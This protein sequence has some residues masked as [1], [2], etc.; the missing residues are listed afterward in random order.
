[1]RTHCKHGHDLTLPDNWVPR[2]SY[3]KGVA[4]PY[5]ACRACH[6][7]SAAASRARKAAARPRK[8]KQLRSAA[9][10]A[11]AKASLAAYKAAAGLTVTPAM[12]ERMRAGLRAGDRLSNLLND[13]AHPRYVTNTTAYYAFA[14]LRPDVHAELIG[15]SR[16]L[17]RRLPASTFPTIIV[18]DP[19]WL[20]AEAMPAVYRATERMPDVIRDE[21]RQNLLLELWEGSLVLV[22][23]PQR[24]RWLYAE[25]FHGYDL[26]SK[27]GHVPLDAPAIEYGEALVHRIADTASLWEN[28]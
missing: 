10:L 22:Q 4:Y 20:E 5:R 23:I 12:I 9:I 18:R 26:A 19:G 13:P 17:P 6:K 8:I 28:A 15:I 14:K 3:T 11:A 24:A 21:V 25:Q 27:Y 7:A 1:M 16:T 2:T